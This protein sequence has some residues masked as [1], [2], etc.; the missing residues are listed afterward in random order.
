[1]SAVDA[2]YIPFPLTRFSANES[3]T[4]MV[5][6]AIDDIIEVFK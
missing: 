4:G 1:M 6:G 3:K 2:F 5:S